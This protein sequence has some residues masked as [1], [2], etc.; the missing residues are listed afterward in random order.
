MEFILLFILAV[1]NTPQTATAGYKPPVSHW[2][3]QSMITL[4]K[5]RED[6]PEIEIPVDK[7]QN[8][9]R[10]FIRTLTEMIEEQRSFFLKTQVDKK[11]ERVNL[12]I[13]GSVFE[14]DEHVVTNKI[15]A[16][17]INSPTLESFYKTQFLAMK[18][19]FKDDVNRKKTD[20]GSPLADE[21]KLPLQKVCSRLPARSYPKLVIKDI[22]PKLHECA[23]S[24]H[25]STKNACNDNNKKCNVKK[26]LPMMLG[27][28]MY[29]VYFLVVD[30]F[31]STRCPGGSCD[32]E[33]EFEDIFR[34]IDLMNAFISMRADR[35]YD[36][37]YTNAVSQRAYS[38]VIAAMKIVSEH[39]DEFRVAPY[40]CEAID[41]IPACQV[42][43]F[44]PQYLLLK[45]IKNDRLKVGD[46][47][48]LRPYKNTDNAKI[49][50]LKKNAVKH[51][52][53]LGA[54]DQLDQNLRAKVKGISEYF[55]GVAKFDQGIADA[56]QAFIT[57]KLK[58]FDVSYEKIANKLKNDM[59]RILEVTN[60]IL[61]IEVADKAASLISKIL[62]EANPI[63]MIFAGTDSAGFKEAAEELG[64]ASANLAKGITLAAKLVDL[65]KD[66]SDITIALRDNQDQIK[67]RIELV[68]KIK[69]N[70]AI[71]IDDD[72]YKFIEEYNNYTPKVDRSRLDQNIEMWGAFQES[73]CDL[74]NGVEG[75]PANIAKGVA[76]GFLLCEK[77]Q[78][79][80]AE[81][82]AVRENIF[83]FQFD[84]MDAI[85][86]VIRG[87]VAKKLSTAI[88]QEDADLLQ[89][90]QLL[91]GFFMT[92]NF[93]Q[94]Q[95]WLYCDKL[96]Y[97][98]V[99]KPVQACVTP[100]GVFT[101][102]ELD[103][104]VAYTDLDRY[105]SIER[106]V[107][108]PSK[109]Q[110]DGDLGFIS[111]SSLEE[112]KTTT[113]RLPLNKTWL[114]DLEWS[115]NGETSAPFVEDFQL[116]LP[117]KDDGP[118]TKKLTTRIVISADTNAG[119]YSSA[120]SKML[121]K[122]PEEHI[123][124]VTVYQEGHRKATCSNEIPNPYSL[125][126][127][128]PKLCH[129]S[130]SAPGKSLLPTT[131]SRWRVQY[132]MQSGLEEEAWKA[133]RSKTNLYFIA[134]LKL[135]IPPSV[136]SR[137]RRAKASKKKERCCNGN[138][139]RFSLVSQQCVDCPTDSTSR[140]GG[141]YCQ[142]DEVT[143]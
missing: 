68:D 83:D 114:Q 75:M 11:E 17:F 91:A 36:K 24:P 41:A 105:T 123:S 29:K 97:R 71:T 94:S 42:A 135:R 38:N 45:K 80:I 5:L 64:Q 104:I 8:S 31:C 138:T 49:I 22:C 107:Y 40:A 19:A 12:D 14:E 127:N 124:Y 116:F 26:A 39:E 58:E 6:L 74:L 134:K 96:Q 3:G 98:N 57:T 137:K 59:S 108:I 51:F 78:G 21:Y 34:Q 141:Y 62:F 133:P 86:G 110:F 15:K 132:G 76:G 73:T 54:I 131:L 129:S 30:K 100:N 25:D 130:A 89:A 125:C 101:N 63:K 82:N 4:S 126:N 10:D 1:F 56:D 113:F 112:L 43:N 55:K 52:E 16:K 121:F 77:L 102:S 109:P 9:Y 143:G 99:G 115:L 65:G 81:F 85:A 84:L 103:N 106:T 117:R 93:L 69:N 13:I 7:G 33:G 118:N 128:L 50:E 2:F 79:T 139:Y 18:N 67:T 142:D 92:Q 27:V 122:L 119:S 90:D 53:L 44:Y 46:T 20:A 136:L 47:R 23:P 32:I 28:I 140:L 35:P 48:D 95:A 61:G 70:Q 37:F 120:E 87:N 88:Q 66:A 60:T 111:I 72:A